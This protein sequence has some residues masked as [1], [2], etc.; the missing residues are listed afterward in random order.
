MLLSI[1]VALITVL[2]L[3]SK[4]VREWLKYFEEKKKSKN[5]K[6]KKK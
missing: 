6:G 2:P 3:Y 1:L 5:K 4:E